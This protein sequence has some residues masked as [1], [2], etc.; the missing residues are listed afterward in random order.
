[1]YRKRAQRKR[2]CG[3]DPNLAPQKIPKGFMNRP[4]MCGF[5]AASEVSDLC[6][7]QSQDSPITGKLSSLF[8]ADSNEQYGRR[9]NVRIFGVKEEPARSC[10]KKLLMLL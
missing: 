1:M 7:K 8:K 5:C 4:F 2:L 9:E 10:T 6:E 3:V